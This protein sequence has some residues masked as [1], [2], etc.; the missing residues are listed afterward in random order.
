MVFSNFVESQFPLTTVVAV[1]L[2][3]EAVNFPVSGKGGS[4]TESVPIC[5]D[6]SVASG[7]V[8]NGEMSV[9]A[10]TGDFPLRK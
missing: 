8:A 3:N 5:A 10:A 9:V 1:L 6:S 4:V 7:I 2:S